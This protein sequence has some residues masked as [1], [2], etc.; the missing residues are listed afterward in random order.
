M[1][2]YSQYD[3][4]DS[5]EMI[6][7]GVGQ[8]ST[9]DLPLNWFNN[10]LTNIINI[11]NP[12]ILQYGDI[13]GYDSLREKMSVWLSKKYYNNSTLV[14]KN[15]IFMT[16]GNTG[17]LQLLIDTFIE[18]G[19]EILI[20][21]PTYFIAKNIFDEY[22]LNINSIPMEDDGINIDI[23]EDKIKKI[24]REDERNL[25]NKIFLYIIPIHHNP[26]S[27]TLSNTKRNKLAELC[28]KYEK[29]Y[30]IADEVYHFL[31]FDKVSNYLPM[32][33]YH[34][35]IF[36]LGSFSK[37]IAPSLRVGWIYQKN[38]S[39]SY[40]L[41]NKLEKSS[42]L[43]S[44]GGLNP[45]GFLLIEQS[46][47]DN[48]IDSLIESNIN[49]L[50]I[51]CDIMYDYIISNFEDVTIIKPKG[52]YFLWLKL[53]DSKNLDTNKFLDFAVNF[54]VKF[55]PSIKF[56]DTCNN[57]IRLSFS[58]YNL[59]DL[60]TGLK[61]LQEA[62]HLY[63]K[64][65]ISILG[66]TGKLGS[67]IVKQINENNN[68]Y[69]LEPIHRNISVN[70]ITDLIIDVS[71]AEGTHNLLEYLIENNINKPLLIGTTGLN[72]NTE[73]LIRLY[74]IK[75]PVGLISNF[76]EGINK[77]KKLITELNNIGSDWK[78]SMI[79]KHHVNKKDKPS[80]T[81]KTLLN[82]INR[83][84]DIDSVREG[85]I[86]GFHQLKIES[87][88]EEIIISH[89][90][91]T[92][93][94]FAKGCLNYIDWLKIKKP[95][96]YYE[97]KD[98]NIPEY[99][100]QTI[101]GST[102]L[103]TESEEFK[104][105]YINEETNKNDKVNFI[106]VVSKDKESKTN[107]YIWK[108]YDIFGEE[109]ESNSNDLI[110]IIKYYNTIHKVNNG[111]LEN[112]N[113]FKVEDNKYYLEIFELPSNIEMKKVEETGLTNLIA[114]LSGLN[115]IGINKYII[116]DTYLIIELSENIDNIDS[117]ILTTLGSIINGD[118]SITNL[119]N[120]C[121]VNIK[122]DT[123]VRMRFYD[124]NIGKESNGNIYG[125]VAACDYLAFVNDLSYDNDLKGIIVLNNDI[126]NVLYKNDKYF[127]CY[128]NRQ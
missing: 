15:Q 40:N 48:A 97:R 19:D 123:Q 79:E 56:S 78:F 112:K 122:E 51:K 124:K 18:S 30:I 14:N 59:D 118:R 89:N 126:I 120:I 6:H 121:Y 75:N 24:I 119:Y 43:D 39:E 23:L 42:I 71:C 107:N 36:S 3:V 87:A 31:N 37:I 33:D 34:P 109:I 57:Y 77:I 70:S 115:V 80:G 106:I 105:K 76:S 67:L 86:I 26:T 125:C 102:F 95:G 32:A 27:I 68:Y 17:A 110:A 101:L 111:K 93:N 114:Q 29:L 74:A 38:T 8:P 41:I 53:S 21:D 13:P 58:Y 81:A 62:Y 94:L 72:N 28:N 65:K 116:E 16:N 108:L 1:P 85:E 100:I 5:T 128:E 54:K 98:T 10:A 99:L 90:A 83:Y 35:K 50:A 63:T 20:E 60:I 11:N 52:G 46:F 127:V 25:Q 84:C 45:L 44:C 88:E 4:P 104:N 47:K 117:D 7:L 2:I 91:K 12:E 49:M 96:L 69:F 55:H 64:T 103:I 113:F 9:K 22:G 92:R 66:S 82:C 61:R 73:K